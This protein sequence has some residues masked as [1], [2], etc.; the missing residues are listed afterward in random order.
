MK[1]RPATGDLAPAEPKFRQARANPGVP[2]P[3]TPLAG[4]AWLRTR[5]ELCTGSMDLTTDAYEYG[6]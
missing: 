6:G 5:H 3:T 1:H 4:R 2:R